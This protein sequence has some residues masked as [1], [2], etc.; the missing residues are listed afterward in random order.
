MVQSSAMHVSRQCM[1]SRSDNR[2][3]SCAFYSAAVHKR[4]MYSDQVT[5]QSTYSY[6]ASS[7]KFQT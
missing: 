1:R 6:A 3:G 5:K 7:E 2:M 4:L